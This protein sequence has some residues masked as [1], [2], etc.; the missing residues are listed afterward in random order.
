VR[1]I[2]VHAHLAAPE[3]ADDLPAVLA[4]AAAA[5]V[6]RIVAVG[7]T[8]DEAERILALSHAHPAIRPAAGLYPTVLDLDAAETLAAFVRRHAAA[9]VAIGEVGLDH[10]AVEEPG[11]A[12]QL[13]ILAGFV[14]L[15]NECALPLNVHSRSAG[16]A[17][18]QALKA[19]GARRVLLHAFDGKAASAAEGVAAGFFFSIPPSIVRS[20]QKQKLV[21]QLPLDRL[22]LETDS[23]VLGPRPGERNEPANALLAC[24]AIAA[25]KG[26]TA[27]QVALATTENAF[28]CFPRL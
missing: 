3:F 24:R 13:D 1:L 10:W 4:R 22:L 15:S 27:E 6:E 19:L 25:L 7:E 2:D 26:C 18:I 5:G 16:R 9:L 28:R 14:A 8:L 20:P 23:P 17:T 21:R 11:W 12:V